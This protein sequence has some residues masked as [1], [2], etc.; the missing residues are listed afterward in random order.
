MTAILS[1]AALDARRFPSDQL[2]ALFQAVLVDD[3]VDAKTALPDRITLEHDAALLA[4]SFRICRQLWLEGVEPGE[5]R[6]LLDLLARDRDLGAADRL[7]FKH[8]RAKLKHF[9]FA[10]ALYGAGHRYP[11]VTDWMTTTLGHLQDAFKNGQAGRVGR[12]VRMTRLLLASLP[13]A[14]MRRERDRLDLTSSDGFLA[15]LRREIAGLAGLLARAD[16]T[17]AEFHAGRKIASRQVAFYDNMRIIRP[18]EEAFCMSRSLAA[19]NGLMGDM[20]DR[21]IERR[22]AGVQDYHRERFGLPT[23]I[24]DRIGALIDRYSSSGLRV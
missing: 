24:R 23:D 14:L 10:C 7:R 11:P 8:A 16:V 17:G 12:R 6:A 15:Y 5:L 22:V 13:S 18:S 19:I 1:R 4:D 21:L 3:M 2:E 20:H 9:R